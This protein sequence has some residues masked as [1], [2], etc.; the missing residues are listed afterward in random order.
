MATKKSATGRKPPRMHRI[1]EEMKQWSAMLVAEVE[2]WPAV[3]S[4]PMF[5]LRCFYRKGRI[6]CGLPVTRAIGSAN[7]IMFK[8][9]PM[10]ETLMKRASIDARVH[11]RREHAALKWAIFELG[12]EEDLHDAIWWLSQAY[13]R[14][15]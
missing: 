1:G 7:S 5:G 2:G 6:F 4:R 13:E 14:A 3:K 10:P 15:K 12:S 9:N 11:L 8:I